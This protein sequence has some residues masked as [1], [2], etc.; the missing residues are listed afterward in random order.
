MTQLVLLGNFKR[1][2]KTTCEYFQ[3]PH[4]YLHRSSSSPSSRSKIP[5][6]PKT[7]ERELR[8]PQVLVFFGHVH[9]NKSIIWASA[10]DFPCW[11][12][13]STCTLYLPGHK[14][15]WSRRMTVVSKKKLNKKDNNQSLNSKFEE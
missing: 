10:H 7:E 8:G 12:V 15:A 1:K 6:T 13:T 3:L 4:H 11:S 5:P 14:W 9:T 2:G